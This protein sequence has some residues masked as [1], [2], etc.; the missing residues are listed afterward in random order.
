MRQ[1]SDRVENRLD[2]A[3]EVV[4]SEAEVSECFEFNE[5]VK[6]QLAGECE[7][8]ED[9]S[10][11]ITGVCSVTTFVEDAVPGRWTVIGVHR[12]DVAES[13]EETAPLGSLWIPFL[14]SS[15]DRS[16]ELEGE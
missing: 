6:L 12:C 13:Q 5:S 10:G 2:P 3:T 16:F 15:K 11:D 14:N 9:D 4:S 7:T 8:F 1:S